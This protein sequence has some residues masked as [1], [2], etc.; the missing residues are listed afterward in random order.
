MNVMFDAENIGLTVEERRFGTAEWRRRAT[1]GTFP[2][3][4]P[5]GTTASRTRYRHAEGPRLGGAAREEHRWGGHA[6]RA[7]LDGEAV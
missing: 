3:V 5:C 1:D 4:F 2:E 6:R 7:R